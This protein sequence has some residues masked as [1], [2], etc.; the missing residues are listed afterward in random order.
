MKNNL[1]FGC[2]SGLIITVVFFYQFIFL[3]KVAFPGDLLVAQFEPF[4]SYSYQGYVPG[5]HPHKSQYGDTIRQLYPWRSFAIEELKQGRFPLWNPYS[6]SGAPLFA[7]IQSAVL[8]PFNFL[9]IFFSYPMAWGILVFLQPL[10]SFIFTFLYSR[11]IGMRFSGALFASLAFSFCLYASVFLEYNTINHVFLW[12]PLL[13]YAVECILEK[14]TVRY[15]C[16][17]IASI[18]FSLFAGHIQIFG[19]IIIFLIC[20]LFYRIYGKRSHK[21]EKIR[22]SLWFVVFI[23][24]AFG[25]SAIQL[26]PTIELIGNAARSV[27]SYNF[28]I[29]KLLLQPAQLVLAFSP[30]FF[31]NPATR[32]Y[33]LQ[34]SYPG[35]AF[36]IGLIPVVFSF[37]ALFNIKKN[38]FIDYF[39]IAIIILLILFVRTPLSELF[40]RIN[41]PFFSTGS[42]TNGLF[43]L[44]FALSILAG[45]GIDF[46]LVDKDKK[47]LKILFILSCLFAVAW[48]YV[49][50]L[51]P[52]MSKQN[53]L[54]SIILLG[55]TVSMLIVGTFFAKKKQIIVLILV[56]LT[57]V[58]LFY[59]FQKFNPFVSVDSVFPKAAIISVLQK[60]TGSERIWGYGEAFIEANLLTQFHLFDPNGYDPLYPKR[61]GEFV[62]SSKNGKI[63]HTFDN[64][65]RSD[66]TIVQGF[67]GKDLLE[68]KQRLR[69]LDV[70]GV[71]YILVK[72][73]T[74]KLLSTR[75]SLWKQDGAWSV[76]KNNNAAP[77]VFLADTYRVVDDAN[78]EKT[79][80]SETFDPRQEILLEEDPGIT[81]D[82][83][84]GTADIVMY[85]PSEVAIKTQSTGKNLLML[86]DEFYPGWA[87]FIDG[88]Q[89]KILKADYAFRSVVVPAGSH[90]VKFQY[91]P[92]SFSFGIGI[93]IISSISTLLVC[94][95]LWKQSKYA[96]N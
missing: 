88:K 39:V 18:V 66:A 84:K 49:V 82:P 96:A 16:I 55:I 44:S 67:G 86:S 33:L 12:M 94:I 72:R 70:L 71:R 40:Y 11:K 8:Y 46:W 74:D 15:A 30:D 28:L 93:S 73:D 24:I 57:C 85:V 29:E 47:I 19:F 52:Q 80:F 41:I 61:Y 53:F 20:Y 77:R 69:V 65:T 89:T 90:I 79:F 26:L 27:Q 31:G 63:L 75:F 7:N 36:Y 10:L 92:Q 22:L 34:D 76:I 23:V 48:A 3:G 14:I 58:D 54:Y 64:T 68:N 13:L 83:R 56:L 91:I 50:I 62:F 6:F 51:H 35:N 60:N 9:Y 25:I 42:P 21:M 17:F 32:N 38:V 87:A 59:F 95:M 43:L 37:Y 81:L 1:L 5:S 78:F 4:R 45:F 2:I